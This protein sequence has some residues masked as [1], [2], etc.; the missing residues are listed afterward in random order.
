MRDEAAQLLLVQ[1]PAV[2][3]CGGHEPLQDV[4]EQLLGGA[5]EGALG[6]VAVRPVSIRLAVVT[7]DDPFHLRSLR[8]PQ[9]KLHKRVGQRR[10]T[11]G[12]TGRSCPRIFPS[13][14]TGSLSA[15]AVAIV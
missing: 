11:S 5:D 14:S 7:L 12:P 2:R 1:N 6:C 10:D 13:S 4:A 9:A 15:Q 3:Q 8:L